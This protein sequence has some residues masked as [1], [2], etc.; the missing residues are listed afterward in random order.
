MGAMESKDS[1]V[2]ELEGDVADL[3]TKYEKLRAHVSD[4]FLFFFFF[5]KKSLPTNQGIL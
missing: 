1:R 4:F 5:Q 3:T 2:N